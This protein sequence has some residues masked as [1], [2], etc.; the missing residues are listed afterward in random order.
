MTYPEHENLE[1]KSYGP[2]GHC[3]YC[4]ADEDLSREHIVPAGLHGSAVIQMASCRSCAK[5]TGRIERS[6]LRGPMWAVRLLRKLRSRRPGD[7]P[8]SERLTV[9]RGG[10]EKEL[11]LPIDEYP[12]LLH[13]PHFDPPTYLTGQHLDRGIH[14][15]GISTVG[16]GPSPADVARRLGVDD[17]KVTQQYEPAAFARMIAKIAFA[18]AVAEGKMS[19]IKGISPV[20]PSILGEEDQIGRWLGTMTQPSTAYPGLLHRVLVHEDLEKGLLIGEVQLFS[21]SP[22]P[23]YAVILGELLH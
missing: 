14:I 8:T 12:V 4:G 13:F 5:I 10:V 23:S 9:I 3:I 11:D 15:S 22:S 16:F 6:V 1:G 7:A 18:M 20:V 19:R 17:V 2:I 21:D